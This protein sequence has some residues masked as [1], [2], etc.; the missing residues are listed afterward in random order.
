MQ[1]MPKPAVVTG[2]VLNETTELD[3]SNDEEHKNNKGAGDVLSDDEDFEYT[4]QDFG[5][6]TNDKSDNKNNGDKVMRSTDGYED[7]DF[8]Y[9]TVQK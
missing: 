8:E 7:S 9:S 3:D 1:N 2:Q 5:K 4:T 6:K